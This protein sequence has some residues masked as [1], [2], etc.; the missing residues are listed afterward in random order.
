VSDVA[1]SL[2][3][4]ASCLCRQK[5]TTIVTLPL[6]DV[7]YCGSSPDIKQVLA[8]TEVARA[9]P[10]TSNQVRQVVFHCGA[11]SQLLSAGASLDELS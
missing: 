8:R 2:P 1:I 11:L 4:G 9:T 10:L 5:H 3:R 6:L 7:L